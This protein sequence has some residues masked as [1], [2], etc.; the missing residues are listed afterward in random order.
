MLRRAAALLVVATLTTPT[1]TA[2]AQV[3]RSFPQT[4]LRGTIVFDTAPVILLN[5]NSARLAPGSRIRDPNNMQVVPGAVIG[6]KHLVH[7]TVDT[8]GLVKDVWILTRQEA[9]NKPWPA[10]ADQAAAWQFDPAAQTWTK[11]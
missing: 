11:P 1:L 10:T 9:A 3:Q 7:Y 6:G 4:A 5:G 2:L 8:Y